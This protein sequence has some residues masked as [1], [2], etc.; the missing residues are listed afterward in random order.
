MGMGLNDNALE[1]KMIMIMVMIMVAIMIMTMVDDC[2]VCHR[3]KIESGERTF[4]A[5]LAIGAQAAGLLFGLGVVVM[6]IVSSGL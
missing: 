1:H 5:S 3:I 6:M 4:G 2:G